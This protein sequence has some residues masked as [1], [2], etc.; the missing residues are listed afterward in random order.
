MFAQ[1][2]R[3]AVQIALAAFLQVQADEL[4]HALAGFF[5]VRAQI[6]GAK[7][8]GDLHHAF[9]RFYAHGGNAR[10]VDQAVGHPIGQ[11]FFKKWP[12]VKKRHAAAGGR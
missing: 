10:R 5:Q 1:R 3:G 2:Q 11:S 8:A 6:L 12:L 7:V 9:G 4:D